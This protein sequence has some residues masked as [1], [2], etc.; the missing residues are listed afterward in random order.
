MCGDLSA[1]KNLIKVAIGVGSSKQIATSFLLPPPLRC[2]GHS[3]DDEPCCFQLSALFFIP[4]FC[5]KCFSL[6][7]ILQAV[8]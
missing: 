1:M 7:A 4:A 3:A 5:R 2:G 6:V 8:E